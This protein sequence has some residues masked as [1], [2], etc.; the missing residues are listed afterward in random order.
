[1]L[2]IFPFPFA[3]YS[4]QH[5]VPVLSLFLCLTRPFS[6]STQLYDTVSEALDL[7]HWALKDLAHR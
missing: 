4:I 2:N 3:S 7:P 6:A 5:S 1:M